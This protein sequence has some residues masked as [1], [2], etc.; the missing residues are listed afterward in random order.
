MRCSGVSSTPNGVADDGNFLV[1]EGNTGTDNVGAD[2]ENVLGSD[3]PD[4]IEGTP[5]VNRLH[6]AGHDDHLLGMGAA[7]VLDGDSGN[8]ELEGAADADVLRGGDQTDRLLAGPGDDSLDGGTG[9]DTLNGMLGIDTITYATR[10]APVAATLDEI[11]ND[12]ADPNTNGISTAGEEGDLDRGV[13]NVTGGDAG[14]ILRAPAA[15][16]VANILRGALGNDTLTAREG[17]ATLDSLFCGPGTDSFA[18]DPADIQNLC[19]T[20]LP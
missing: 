3:G 10:T 2:V 5:D 1:D 19:E 15:D 16:A 9:P 8:D 14:D 20:A 7:D 13:E 4:Y 6:G 11:R 18:K 17:T 12:G